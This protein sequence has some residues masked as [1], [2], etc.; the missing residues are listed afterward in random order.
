MS[1]EARIAI[2]LTGTRWRCARAGDRDRVRALVHQSVRVTDGQVA[3]VGG[4]GIDEVI[5]HSADARWSVVVRPLHI[6]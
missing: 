3:E 2:L 1:L 6:R 4:R 5:A